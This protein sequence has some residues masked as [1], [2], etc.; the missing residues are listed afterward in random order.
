MLVTVAMV[1]SDYNGTN[2]TNQPGLS[3]LP[4]Y[5]L[6]YNL[7]NKEPQ[8]IIQNNNH[9]INTFNSII[10]IIILFNFGTRPV[11]WRGEWLVRAGVQINYIDHSI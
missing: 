2:G 5:Q 10:T 1:I 8:T 3:I 6:L 7:N 4:L 9:R 11:I